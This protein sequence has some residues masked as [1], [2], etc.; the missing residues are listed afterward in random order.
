MKGLSMARWRQLARVDGGLGA[1]RAILLRFLPLG[2]VDPERA[3]QA[4][5]AAAGGLVAPAA[6][7]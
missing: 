5:I 7:A 6:P 2:G 4:P 3:D 1:G